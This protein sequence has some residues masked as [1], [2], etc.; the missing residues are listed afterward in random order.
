MSIKKD[1]QKLVVAGLANLDEELAREEPVARSSG[2]IPSTS[3]MLAYDEHA[4]AMKRENEELKAGLGKARPLALDLLDDSP[5]HIGEIEPERVAALQ[6]NLE[7]NPQAN[8]ILVRAK[9]DGRFEI[10]AGRHR[11]QAFQNL[12][13]ASID[14]V[15]REATDDEALRMVVYDNY[16]APSLTDYEKYAGLSLI[17]T[18]RGL[19]YEA[20]TAESGVKNVGKLFAFERLPAEGQEIIKATPAKFGANL[21]ANLAPLADQ[22]PERVVDALR[23]IAEGKLGQDSAVK[24]VKSPPSPLAEARVQAAPSSR[25]PREWVMAGDQR[26]AGYIV[27]GREV[28]I[29]FKD[30]AATQAFAAEMKALLTRFAKKSQKP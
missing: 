22:Y 18:K 8:P 19:T 24:F 29:E 23:L 25:T 27:R 2:S 14:A 21:F 7:Q 10:L 28:Q 5:D 3:T 15:I 1:M 9:A 30:E 6:S 26:Y 12:G 11:V 17:R 16:L 13:R 4:T 20:L